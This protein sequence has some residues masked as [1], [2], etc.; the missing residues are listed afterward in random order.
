MVLECDPNRAKL[1]VSVK[2]VEIAKER[3]T[4]D[5]YMKEQEKEETG[6]TLGDILGDAFKSEE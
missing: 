1:V 6:S 2:A 5:S 3:E 4:F